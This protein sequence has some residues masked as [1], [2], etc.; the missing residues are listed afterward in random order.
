ML[1]AIVIDLG[2]SVICSR[3]AAETACLL[4]TMAERAQSTRRIAP[5]VH[6]KKV[7]KTLPDQQAYIISMIPSIGPVTARALL[8]HFG[9]IQAVF[10]A[11]TLDLTR[12]S[13]IGKQTAE[14]IYKLARTEYKPE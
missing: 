4:F 12:V 14:K 2:V 9:S 10:S 13:G 1:A 11:S 7:P 6:G 8:Q 3:D 5:K